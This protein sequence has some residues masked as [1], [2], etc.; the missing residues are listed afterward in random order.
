RFLH[1]R[2][3]AAPPHIEDQADRDQADDEAVVAV[4]NE[5]QRYAGQGRHAHHRVEVYACLDQDQA[6]QAASEDTAVA[7][8]GLAGYLESRVAEQ[9]GHENPRAHAEETELL[10]D[11]GRDHVGV[12]LRQVE[13]LLHAVADPGAVHTTGS[14]CD[15]RLDHL[16]SIA[17]YVTFR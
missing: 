7:V 3:L 4:G 10:T 8:L 12:R 5:R 14:D 11:Q 2:G 9:S 6:G 15:L 16:E 1:G 13:G 17:G